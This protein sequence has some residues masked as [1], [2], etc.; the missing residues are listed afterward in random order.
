METGEQPPF[1]IEADALSA[2][3]TLW[4][5]GHAA[6]VVGGAVRDA[7]LGLPSTD[8]DIATDAEPTRLLTIFP[9]GSY[10]NQ[11]GTVRV[12]DLEITTFRRDHRYADHRRPERVTFTH[13]A[14]EDLARRD[15]TINAIAWGRSR[16]DGA[17]RLVDPADGIGDLRARLV[18]AV[19]DPTSR[20]DEDAL[21][22]LRAIRIAARLD[23]AIEPLTR[24]AME[25]H[26]AD[27]AWVSE[28][29][30]ATEVRDVLRSGS[31]SRAFRLMREI[32][33]LGAV[34]PELATL[35]DIDDARS[36][37]EASA[38]T[39]F[40]HALASVDAATA[41]APGDES[42]ALA[43][44]LHPAGPDAARAALERLRVRAREADMIGRLVAEMQADYDP[45][46]SDVDVRRFMRRLGPALVDDLVRLRQVHD[47]V[48]PEAAVGD[49]TRELRGRLEAQREAGVPLTLADLRVH[50]RDLRDE[51][52]IAEGPLVGELLDELL[53]LVTVEPAANERATLLAAAADAVARHTGAADGDRPRAAGHRVG[54]AE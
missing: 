17:T 8:W 54:S 13:D 50:G 30:I 11:F 51:L 41:M 36:S 14:F 45:A 25:A 33:L 31:P 38:D 10:Q 26:A 48:E 46:W 37:L 53:D 28:E 9:A 16:P 40:A 32:G 21:R 12:G 5:N 4:A 1:A 2:L 3:R 29:R 35:A 42:L 49:R 6:L 44:L 15:L 47:G 20:F 23:F 52:G 43:A 27:I 18:R 22:L 19:G 7:L 24:R 39:P 34:L